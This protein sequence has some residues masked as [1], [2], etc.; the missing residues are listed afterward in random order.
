VVGGAVIVLM[1]LRARRSRVTSGNVTHPVV[2]IP[3][4][5]A[6]A[7]LQSGRR[8]PHQSESRKVPTP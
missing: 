8:V 1:F 5:V 7:S 2:A 6:P 4:D 3:R